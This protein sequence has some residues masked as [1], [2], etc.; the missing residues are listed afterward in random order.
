MRTA[1]LV[2]AACG[3]TAAPAPAPSAAELGALVFHDTAMS[4]PAGQACADCHADATA[5]RD[6][7]TDHTTSMGVVA[8]RFG[9]RNAPSAM[10]TAQVP[11]LHYDA[12]E[13]QLAGGLFWDG[14]ADS[15][16]LQAEGPLMN[17]LEMNNP[18]R[19]T[20][21][22]K[23]RLSP[24]ADQFR[25]V[26][27]DDALG[28]EDTAFAHLTDALAAYERSPVLAPFS[29]KYDHYLAGSEHLTASEERGRQIFEDPARG[30]CASCHPAPLFT[31]FTYANLG[32]PAYA[33]NLFYAQPAAL[34][35]EGA[36]FRDRGLGGTV[37]NAAFDGQFRVPTLRNVARTAP[38]GHNG[39]FANLTYFV[40][41]LATRDTGSPDVG[42]CSRA[43]TAP[44]AACAWPPSEFPANVDHHVGHLPLSSADIDDLV[45]FLE[46]LTDQ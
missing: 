43:A 37:D 8:G 22:D 5:F 29:S 30:N 28:N 1:L 2:L 10:Y 46:T 41:F 24:Y 13:Q 16:E 23:L 44:T 18:D 15:L 36:A 3:A 32:V 34:N 14:R 33:N 7:E 38:Y 42:T 9:S 20:V 25:A 17:P 11:A 35:P 4:Q 12:T 21:V 31:N 19:E 26:Y 39:Y 6:P 40:E 45:A 27:G